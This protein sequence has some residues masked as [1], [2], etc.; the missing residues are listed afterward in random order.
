MS[1]NLY[2]RLRSLLPESP[3]LIGTVTGINA[4]EVY[5]TLPD[6]SSLKA[7]GEATVGQ[8]VYVRDGLIEGLAPD[9]TV[10]TLSV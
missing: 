5:L 10:V 9:L 2:K 4:T 6:G 8:K 7:R 1:Y 3:L